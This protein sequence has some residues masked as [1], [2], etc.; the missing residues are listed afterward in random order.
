VAVG[1]VLVFSFP[2]RNLLI[3]S[4]L[5]IERRKLM[6]FNSPMWWVEDETSLSFTEYQRSAQT[7]KLYPDTTK[8]WYPT[9][10]LCGEAGEVAEKVKKFFR[11]GTSEEEFKEVVKK[12]LGDV[13]WYIQALATDLGFSLEEVAKINIAKLKDRQKRNKVHGDGDNR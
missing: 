12:E 4:T 13:L 7:T 11:D 5:I 1:K 3:S 6:S 8:I 10:G 2:F 9:L